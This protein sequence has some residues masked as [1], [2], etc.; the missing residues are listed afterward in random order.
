MKL[1]QYYSSKLP[2]E[3]IYDL[4]KWKFLSNTSMVSDRFVALYHLKHYMLD[5]QSRKYGFSSC[6]AGMKCAVTDYFAS[7]VLCDK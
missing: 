3:Y 1:L 5:N 7:I 2:L 6:T 4:Q